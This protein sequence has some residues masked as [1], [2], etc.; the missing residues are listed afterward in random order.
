ME[1]YQPALLNEDGTFASD[2]NRKNIALQP[3]LFAKNAETRDFDR[4]DPE[5][6]RFIAECE[7]IDE[8]GVTFNA[9][10]KEVVS[11]YIDPVADVDETMASELAHDCLLIKMGGGNVMDM[12]DFLRSTLTRS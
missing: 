4:F 5:T 12:K 6:L 7:E 3:A 8:T 9:H 10:E 1:H 2:D 11:G